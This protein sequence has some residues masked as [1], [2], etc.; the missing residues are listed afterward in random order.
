LEID[1]GS[2]VS[3]VFGGGG[4]G[5]ILGSIGGI[6]GGIFGGPIGAMIGQAIGNMLQ[7]AIGDATKQAVDTLQKEHGMPKFL[8]DEV[9]GKIDNIIGGLLQ[10]VSADAAQQASQHVGNAFESFKNDFA[11]SLVKMVVD[12]MKEDRENQGGNGGGSSSSKPANG[13]SWLE[14]LAKA[15]GASLGDKAAKMVE[16][17]DKVASTAGGQGKEAA[18]ANTEATLELQ[19]AS[20]MFSLMQNAFSAAIKAI[21]EG[22][23]Q[24]ARKG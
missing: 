15:M 17:S 13:G 11:K 8:A 20:Q 14:A 7:Q 23:S 12:Q 22:L 2:A 24:A 19:G 16:L 6:V 10:P 9:K 4:A 18:K 1:M 21:G 3:S 5:G